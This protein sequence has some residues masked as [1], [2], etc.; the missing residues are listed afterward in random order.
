MTGLQIDSLDREK[1]QHWLRENLSC[2]DPV[3]AKL[4]Q[5]VGLLLD[6]AERQNLVADATKPVFWTR[7]VIDSAQLLLHVPRET[8]LQWV[9]LGSGA[10][11]PGLVNAI[12]APHHRFTLVERRPLRTDWLNRAVDR[13]DIKNVEVVSAPV[14]ALPDQ[15]FDV[16][17]ARAFAPMP[18][19]FAMAK[20]F[21][22]GKTLWIL[23]KGKSAKQEMS[24]IPGWQGRFHVEPSVTDGESGII[25]GSLQP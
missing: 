24:A 7:H 3:I 17:T 18:K 11:L 21:A 15:S 19:L 12:I 9:D 23:P 4:D 25:V 20:R 5:F 10:G 14:S 8:A 1:A 13:L 6:E 16:I 2:S 22:S